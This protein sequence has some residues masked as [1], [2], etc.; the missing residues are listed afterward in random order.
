MSSYL[1]KL[2]DDFCGTGPK[3]PPFPPKPHWLDDK[4]MVE[5][6]VGAALKLFDTSNSLQG[7]GLDKIMEEGA[8]KTLSVAIARLEKE[9]R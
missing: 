9:E 3:R 1:S 7:T 2:I 5:E 6:Q 4:L 8:E